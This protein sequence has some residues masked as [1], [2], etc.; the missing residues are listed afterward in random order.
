MK[1]FLVS[2]K[3]F[4]VAGSDINIGIAPGK[5]DTKQLILSAIAV[6]TYFPEKSVRFIRTVDRKELSKCQ[7]FI[8]DDFTTLF[9]VIPSYHDIGKTWE[10]NCE[11]ILNKYSVYDNEAI[12]FIMKSVE[13]KICNL[14]PIDCL[15]HL[16]TA[17]SNEKDS[18]EEALEVTLR[19]IKKAIKDSINDR[20]LFY[21]VKAYV[22]KS[23]TNYISLPLYVQGWRNILQNVDSENN[24]EY[25]I[26]PDGEDMFVI[27]SLDKDLVM[28]KHVKGIK[29]LSYSGRF[30]VK[31]ADIQ[32][33][34]NV[35]AKLPTVRMKK[36]MHSA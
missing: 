7:L 13:E 29:G 25:A 4:C 10:K 11:K 19:L 8:N 24:I 32:T 28:K 31:V 30:F 23:T 1:K 27:E 26:F 6:L 18:F 21:T 3:V 22:E 36:I 16:Y 9:P 20:M 34:E 35:I 14:E 12:N 5:F 17:S 15:M 2:N 33:A